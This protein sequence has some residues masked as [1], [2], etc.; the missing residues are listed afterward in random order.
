MKCIVIFL[1]ALWSLPLFSQN[2]DLTITIPNVKGTDGEIVIG[3]Y[4][5]KESFPLDDKQYKMFTIDGDLFQGEYT[6]KNLP[7]GEYAVAL[8]HDKNSD[9]ICNTNFL[10]FP[11]E[12]YGFSRN[13]RPKLS[14]P[15]FEDC[16][17]ELKENLAI[18]IKL[19]Y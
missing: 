18:T 3:L 19:I 11:K 17:F 14:A 1:A 9:K 13:F 5:N 12:G 15:K 8:Y 7:G 2:Y 4:N 10:G 6:I 16:N